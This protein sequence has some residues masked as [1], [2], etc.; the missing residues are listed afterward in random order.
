MNSDDGAESRESPRVIMGE[1]E[2]NARRAVLAEM[3]QAHEIASVAGRGAGNA[4]RA[5]LLEGRGPDLFRRI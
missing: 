3:R 4:E 2:E 5:R 1:M